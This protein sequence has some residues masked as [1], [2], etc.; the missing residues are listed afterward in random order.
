MSRTVEDLPRDETTQRSASRAISRM[1][2]TAPVAAR[3][4]PV[5]RDRLRTSSKG[6]AHSNSARTRTR[7]LAAHVC[8]RH[9]ERASAR[10]VRETC[11]STSSP[12]VG[13][14]IR[15]TPSSLPVCP[16]APGPSNSV[17]MATGT[18]DVETMAADSPGVG[19]S[20][21]SDCSTTTV[22]SRG[23]LGRLE[24]TTGSTRMSRGPSAPGA[25][26][27]AAGPLTRSFP[28]SDHPAGPCQRPAGGVVDGD[29]R[30]ARQISWQCC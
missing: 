8:V 1:I 14:G 6:P 25:T 4:A 28:R 21:A 19:S 13:D 10:A 3:N 20:P 11:A 2:A 17:R 27:T 5:L 23:E 29:S 22:A 26:N 18:S 30:T 9:R 12:P 7:T 15:K 24:S 16:S